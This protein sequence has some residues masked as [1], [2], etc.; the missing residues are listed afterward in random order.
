MQADIH[1]YRRLALEKIHTKDW[2]A[3]TFN[4]RE[5]PE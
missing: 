1:T 4:G 3:N 5:K 2:L